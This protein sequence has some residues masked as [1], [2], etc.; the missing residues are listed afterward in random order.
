VI[1]IHHIENLRDKQESLF[2]TSW[3]KGRLYLCEDSLLL[4]ISSTFTHTH[5]Q[6]NP[7][8]ASHFSC[9]QLIHA[10]RNIQIIWELISGIFPIFSHSLYEATSAKTSRFTYMY[11]N[12]ARTL[13]HISFHWPCSYPELILNSCLKMDQE[14]ERGGGPF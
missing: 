2:C 1:K 9:H 11:S 8:I 3:F 13:K 6:N 12:N 4:D 5:L 10:H 7:N 14:G